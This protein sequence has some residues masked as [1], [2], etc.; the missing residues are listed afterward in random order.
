M[1][2]GQYYEGQIN[3]KPLCFVELS[4]IFIIIKEQRFLGGFLNYCKLLSQ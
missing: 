2:I 3:E 1:N 4:L